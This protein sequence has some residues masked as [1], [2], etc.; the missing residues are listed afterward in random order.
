MKMVGTEKRE[1]PTT[2]LSYFV[3]EILDVYGRIFR[4]FVECVIKLDKYRVWHGY[5][6]FVSVP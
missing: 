1:I 4:R 5:V 3:A 6:K 2:N